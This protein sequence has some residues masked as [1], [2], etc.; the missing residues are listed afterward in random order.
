MRTPRRRDPYA[1]IRKVMTLPLPHAAPDPDLR[2]QL[3]AVRGL[4]LDLNGVLVLSGAL[5]PGAAEAPAALHSRRFPYR[6]YMLRVNLR[7]PREGLRHSA[8]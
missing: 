2:R 7:K 4:L 3:D 8:R 6:G 5:L 1:T